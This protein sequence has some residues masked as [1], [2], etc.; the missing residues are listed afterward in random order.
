MTLYLNP[1][2]A[3]R[4]TDA[5]MSKFRSNPCDRLGEALLEA[6]GRC[7]TILRDALDSA[8]EPD[9]ETLERVASHGRRAL[10]TLELDGGRTWD[11]IL[12]LSAELGL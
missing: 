4:R 11:E 10:R 9:L 5:L 8:E 3:M 7:R 6:A 12:V 2:A 1:V